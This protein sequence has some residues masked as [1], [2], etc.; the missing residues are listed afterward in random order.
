M[1]IFNSSVSQA[2][3][4]NAHKKEVKDRLFLEYDYRYYKDYIAEGITYLDDN[5]V[6]F[7]MDVREGLNYDEII[8]I[9]SKNIQITNI[10]NNGYDLHINLEQENSNTNVIYTIED[11]SYKISI[12][13]LVDSEDI[14]RNQFEAPANLSVNVVC[15]P[16][17][18]A[19]VGIV[20]GGA[21]CAWKQHEAS[22]NCKESYKDCLDHSSPG[23]SCSYHFSS[24]SCGGECQIKPVVLGL[25]NHF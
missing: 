15:P 1:K 8:T 4:E 24:T 2:S 13:G 12:P 3:E 5:Y 7:D 23:T 19:L 22:T 18:V 10:N 9:D 11:Y 16:C 20:V 25:V 21:Y 6:I 14:A 17:I